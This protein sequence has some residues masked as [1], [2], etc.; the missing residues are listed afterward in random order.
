[1]GK[2]SRQLAGV[3]VYM[4]LAPLFLISPLSI[5]I[6][7][8]QTQVRVWTPSSSTAASAKEEASLVIHSGENIAMAAVAWEDG[9]GL[10][11]GCDGKLP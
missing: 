11:Y 4:F 7:H 8:H 1:M 6:H 2:G 5:T 9:R 10:A 3:F